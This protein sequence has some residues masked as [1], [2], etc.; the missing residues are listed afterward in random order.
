MIA[1]PTAL[2]PPHTTASSSR[3]KFAVL[4][5]LLV[6][7]AMAAFAWTWNYEQSLRCLD[8]YGGQAANLIRTAPKVEILELG[9][10]ATADASPINETVEV[11]GL[12]MTIT[13]RI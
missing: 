6:A 2:P 1:T 4:G 3:G 9:V 5:I 10:E 12:P 13:K 7:F 11:A 8:L